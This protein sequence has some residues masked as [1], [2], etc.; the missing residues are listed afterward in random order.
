[1]LRDTFIFYLFI[2]VAVLIY[3]NCVNYITT[4]ENINNTRRGRPFSVIEIMDPS[5]FEIK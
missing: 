2:Y 4:H 1:M 5:V 3:C